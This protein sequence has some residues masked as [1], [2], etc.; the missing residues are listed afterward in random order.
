MALSVPIPDD[1]LNTA[2]MV[3]V[4]KLGLV[5]K[6]QLVGRQIG[7][8]EFRKKYCRNRAPE[9]VRLRIFD[10]FP[11]TDFKNGGWVVHPRSRPGHHDKTYI[12]EYEASIWME[13]H[14]FDIEWDKPLPRR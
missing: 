6:D 3:T 5:P 7:I 2:V 13:K 14:K 8:D 12:Y 1:W 4:K 9:W 10:A 11:E